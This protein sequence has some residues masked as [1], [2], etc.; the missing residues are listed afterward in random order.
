M[1]KNHRKNSRGADRRDRPSFLDPDYID[2]YLV[3]I[4][5]SHIT[6]ELYTQTDLIGD[7]AYTRVQYYLC[8]RDNVPETF[9]DQS[10]ESVLRRSTSGVSRALAEAVSD[11]CE[12][13]REACIQKILKP[14]QRAVCRKQIQGRMKKTVDSIKLI[15]RENIMAAHGIFSL[16]GCESQA[17]DAVRTAAQKGTPVEFSCEIH[18]KAG[19]RKSVQKWYSDLRNRRK[20]YEKGLLQAKLEKKKKME[21]ELALQEK[22]LTAIPDRYR[23]LYPRARAMRRRF[24]LHVGPTNSGKTYEAM[25]KLARASSGVYLGP[26]RLLAYEQFESLNARGILC[27]LVTGEEQELVPGAM[28]T[29]STVEMANLQAYYE[30]AVIDEAQLITDSQRGGAWTN[31]IL[32]ICAEEVHVCC[33]PDA[34]EMLLSIIHECQD[35]VTVTH[36][37]RLTPLL[38]DTAHFSFPGGVMKGDALIVFS[39]RSVHA[40]AATIRDRGLKCSVVYGALPYDVR[41][42]QARLF[43]SGDNDVVVATDAIGLGMNLPIRRVV[44]LETEKYDGYELRSLRTTEIKQI[45][46]R[47][48]RYG[49]YSTGYYTALSDKGSIAKAVK[50]EY[51][52][53]GSPVIDFPESLLSVDLSLKETILRWRRAGVH[54]G[55]SRGDT[56]RM[57]DLLTFIPGDNKQLQYDLITMAFDEEDPILLGL[58]KQMMRAE[59]AG[60]RFNVEK[61]LPG[62]SSAGYD[63]GSLEKLERKFRICDL[64]YSYLR[65]F[66]PVE[67]LMSEVSAV[68]SAITHEIIRILE[69]QRFQGRRCRICGRKL[70]WNYEY[71]ICERCYG[72]Y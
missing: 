34:E 46:G 41:H 13:V 44:F 17:S 23:D 33:S 49:I 8:T 3:G 43:A 48:G 67:S 14:D 40:V 70:P 20:E 66:Y 4:V 11:A 42:E 59:T 31:A 68:K 22:V 6:N 57:L 56:D 63:A 15:V 55:W 53:V 69:K 65:K 45:A 32:G 10:L 64:L 71:G 29:A 5:R 72:G 18:L 9:W 25:K 19:E 30:V 62:V 38:Q 27:S 2:D 39:R 61:E 58:W 51:P 52:P 1:E 26:L 12:A 60:M 50:A 37:D 54:A 28:I 16:A 7:Y 21:R 35:E 36:H 47:A 24:I